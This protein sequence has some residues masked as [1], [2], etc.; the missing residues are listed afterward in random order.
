[1]THF[2]SLDLPLL[3]DVTGG[4]ELHAGETCARYTNPEANAACKDGFSAGAGLAAQA[5][6]GSALFPSNENKQATGK[7]VV[8]PPVPKR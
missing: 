4:A 3:D 8:L 2:E 7:G 1:M 5:L 6:G